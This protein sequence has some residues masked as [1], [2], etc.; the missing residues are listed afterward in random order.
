MSRYI[1]LIVM[2]KVSILIDIGKYRSIIAF[3]NSSEVFP[4]PDV[5]IVQNFHKN[6]LKNVYKGSPSTN[7]IK[8]SRNVFKISLQPQQN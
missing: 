6:M 3:H 4:N 2:G 7:F 1:I 8:M 5:K